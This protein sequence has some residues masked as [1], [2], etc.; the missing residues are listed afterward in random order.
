MTRYGVEVGGKLATGWFDSRQ[1]AEYE[2]ATLRHQGHKLV[3]VVTRK[4]NTAGGHQQ[5]SVL[6]PA[7][8]PY[9]A[10]SRGTSK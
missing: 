3:R 7:V 2:A 4:G 1:F 10:T 5:M 9:F 6:I 8:T